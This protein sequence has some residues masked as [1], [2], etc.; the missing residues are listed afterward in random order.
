MAAAQVAEQ[1][2]QG[3]G[4]DA[5]AERLS[6]LV[7]QQV[8]LVDHHVLE[9]GQ[10]VASR[11]QQGVVHA[12][13][14]RRLGAGAREAP[15]AAAA[16]GA[17]AT[18]TGGPRG[19]QLARQVGE[20]GEDLRGP[21]GQRREVHVAAARAPDQIGERERAVRVGERLALGGDGLVEAPPAEVVLAAHEQRPAPSRRQPGGDERQLGAGQLPL[22][23][24]GLGA[25]EDAAAGGGA[26]VGRRQQV[27]EAL[28]HAGPGLEHADAAAPKTS[29][30]ASA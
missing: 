29:A 8:R 20:R 6:G 24:L 1:L 14:V 11:E 26:R 5:V 13:Q 15:V 28:A 23:R 25:D 22:Q 4:V 3:A 16:G 30:A 18:Q 19:A 2:V 21:V 7:I 27:P 10:R 17:V 12:D 9:R